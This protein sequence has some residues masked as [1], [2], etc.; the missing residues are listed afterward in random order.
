MLWLTQPW[1]KNNPAFLKYVLH[2][3]NKPCCKLLSTP[4]H[5]HDAKMFHLN[6]NVKCLDRSKALLYYIKRSSLKWELL[7]KICLPKIKKI[8]ILKAKY[9]SYNLIIRCC[10]H[11]YTGTSNVWGCTDCFHSTAYKA[12]IHKSFNTLLTVCKAVHWPFSPQTYA[13]HSETKLCRVML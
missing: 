4:S 1:V 10:A 2:N 13:I 11:F 8:L 12:F 9:N 7:G 3:K 5:D 6:L